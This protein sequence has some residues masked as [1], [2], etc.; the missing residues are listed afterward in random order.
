MRGLK[1]IKK[2][3]VSLLVLTVIPIYSNARAEETPTFIPVEHYDDSA[4]NELPDAP[5]EVITDDL[6]DSADSLQLERENP[7]TVMPDQEVEHSLSELTSDESYEVVAGDTL[8]DIAIKYKTTVDDIKAVNGLKKD[9]IFP[10]MK[11]KIVQGTF[12]IRVDKSDNVL[13]LYFNNQL[14][15]KYDVSTGKD[16]STPAGEFKIINKIENPTWYKAGAIVPPDSPDNIL[17]PRWLGFDTPGYGIHG[18]TMPESIGE[19]ASAGCVRMKNEDVE[20]LFSSVPV[21]TKVIITE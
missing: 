12:E 15:K 3:L 19:Q 20:A 5:E 6:Q 2:T 7:K 9:I 8:Y 16:S 14:V 21:G 11:L 17:G 4:V 1:M 13:K 10:G 18:T